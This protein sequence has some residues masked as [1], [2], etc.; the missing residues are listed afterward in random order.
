MKVF[1]TLKVPIWWSLKI[2]F[3][4]SSVILTKFLKKL[5]HCQWNCKRVCYSLS[6]TE[7]KYELS[8]V[9]GR[10]CSLQKKRLLLQWLN[11]FA[12]LKS[13]IFRRKV[14]L[15]WRLSKTLFIRKIRHQ[16]ELLYKYVNSLKLFI[17]QNAI[18]QVCS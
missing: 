3:N 15:L 14:F 6:F 7:E 8:L 2:L 10:I 5:S 18:V 12:D 16:A 13:L 9:N 11:F 4:C 1:I 17:Y